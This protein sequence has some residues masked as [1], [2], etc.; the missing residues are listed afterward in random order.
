VAV[1]AAMDEIRRQVGL[2]YDA[3][4]AREGSSME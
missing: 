1:M 4:T 2:T 3:D